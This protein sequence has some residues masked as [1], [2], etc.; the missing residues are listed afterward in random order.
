[1]VTIHLTALRSDT[2]PVSV[3]D[4]TAALRPEFDYEDKL[5][6]AYCDT[7]QSALISDRPT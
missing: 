2:I 5:N 7:H 6:Y 3:C 4:G 1:M